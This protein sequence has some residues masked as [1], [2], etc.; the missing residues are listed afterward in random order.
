M[1]IFLFVAFV[2]SDRLQLVKLYPEGNPETRLSLRGAG[3]LYWYCNRH[4]L[5][6]INPRKA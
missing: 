1:S 4:G 3:K 5:F 2:T 6:A